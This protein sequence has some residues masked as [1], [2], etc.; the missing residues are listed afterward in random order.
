MLKLMGMKLFTILHSTILFNDEHL[1]YWFSHV[2]AQAS[3]L[4]AN[5]TAYI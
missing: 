5:Q 3:I 2:I 1:F 4:L